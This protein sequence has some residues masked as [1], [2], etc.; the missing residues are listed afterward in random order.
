MR[1]RGLGVFT[2]GAAMVLAACAGP[3]STASPGSSTAASSASASNDSGGEPIRIGAI[4]PLTGDGSAYGPGMEAAAHIAVDEVNAAGGIDGRQVDLLVEDD[5][6]NPDQGVRAANKLIDLN[7]VD[8][9][10]GT[11]ASSVTLAIAPLTI[12]ANIVEMNTSGSPD[13]T[14]LNDNGTVFRANATDAALGA[15]VA[16]QFFDDGNRT[17]TVIT[18]NAAGAIGLAQTVRDVF[19]TA[20]GEV[21]DYIEYAEG[22]ASYNT[23][24]NRALQNEPD[25]FFL[26]CYTP[27]GTQVIRA[28]YE[29]GATA[30]FA[31]PAWCLN[32]Q[33]ADA[34]GADV[35]E[36][37]IAVDLVAVKDSEA[38][39]RL[40]DAYQAATGEDVFNNVYAVHIYDSVLLL[41]LA[42]QKAGT[43]EGDQVGRAMLEISNPPGE[44]VESFEAGLT[45]L[46]AGQE[47]NFDGAGGPIDFNAAGD[48]APF[49]GMFEFQNGEAVLTKTFSGE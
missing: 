13:I 8:A 12:E 16:Q 30:P 11:W 21:L 29:G 47:I 45:A 4:L 5:A 36:G 1:A 9:I 35:V 14:D 43:T 31:A 33:L 17:M 18:N 39:Q 48:M 27:D 44:K 32:G 10:V 37:D 28:A 42:M 24:V 25:I 26:S 22:Q 19:K 2:L 40:A 41:A 46:Q 6:T 7:H 38:Y 20:G 23:E 3:A 49:V 15:T 34:V